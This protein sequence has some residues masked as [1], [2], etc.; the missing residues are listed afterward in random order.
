[1]GL[2]A[3][4]WL[5]RWIAQLAG[6][7]GYN[8]V[9]ARYVA[10]PLVDA[11]LRGVDSHGVIRLPVYAQRIENGLVDPAATP[12]VDRRAGIARVDA[13]RAAGQIAARATCQSLAT[14][15]RPR[16]RRHDGT[17]QRAFRRRR[18]LRAS[19]ATRGFV[20]FVVS[21]SEP[22]VVPLGGRDA[23][24]GTNPLAFVA[25]T[26]GGEPFSLDLATGT[27]TMGKVIVAQTRDEAIPADWVWT[28]MVCPPP[29]RMRSPHCYP[30]AAQKATRS[31]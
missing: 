7:L 21:N 23:L 30:S 22:I 9:D 17:G 13:H 11:N 15:A 5:E 31:A 2:V 3:P 6:A 10:A 24:L 28:P 1:M 29:T 20:A 14:A 4:P 26:E 12:R 16:D 27:S 25:P 8:D 19:L 18:F